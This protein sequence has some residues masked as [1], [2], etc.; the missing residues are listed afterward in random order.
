MAPW[1]SAPAAPSIAPLETAHSRRLA[2]IHAGAFARPWSALDFERL[3]VERSV[4]G[5][6]LFLGAGVAQGFS[7]SR[8]AADEAEILT[9]A[10]A[11]AAR[12]K[13]HSRPL[14]ERH[15]DALARRGV[16]RLHLEVDEGNA[17]ALALYRRFGFTQSGRREGYYLKTDGSRATALTMSVD[18]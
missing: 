11:P 18:L 10:I 3:L 7:L 14:L 16:A 12:G 2:E 13:G 8:I 5:D 17:P 15:L 6:G 9:I 4:I 1:F